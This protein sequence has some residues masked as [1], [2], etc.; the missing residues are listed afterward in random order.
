MLLRLSE[1]L[2]SLENFKIYNLYKDPKRV[3]LDNFVID[4]RKARK[5]SVFFALKGQRNDG[6]DFVKDVHSNG[7]EI[8]VVE[9]KLDNVGITQIV[10]NSSIKALGKIAKSVIEKVNPK[11]IGITG[12]NGK[13]TTKELMYHLLKPQIPIFR[14]PGNLNTEIGLPLSILNYYNREKI[15]VLE[16]GISKKGDME[17][18]IFL[19]KPDA[20]VFLNS[21]SAHIGNFENEFEIFEEKSKLMRSIKKGIAVLY[22][23]E[24]RF[25]KLSKELEKEVRSFFF[26]QKNGHVRL[27][28][29][30]YDS[31]NFKTFAN[32]RL[33]SENLS[34]ELNGIWNRGQLLDLCAAMCMVKG[35]G[36]DIVSST[37]NNFSPLE[38]RFSVRTINE[39]IVI[40]DTYNAS[41][42]SLK[43]ALN[44][45]K[46]I[47]ARRKI[48]VLGSI[49]EQGRKS[50]ETHKKLGEI[51]KS[52]DIDHV[53]VYSL[54]PDIEYSVDIMKDKVVMVSSELDEITNFLRTFLQPE[55]LIYFKASRGVEIEK[56]MEKI[57][58]VY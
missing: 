1:I 24:E 34:L 2:D 8:A 30:K 27:L 16:L 41:I 33:F 57:C 58:S 7:A 17:N 36:F 12:S 38:N 31:K 4:S 10:V 47:N 44:A 43:E 5:G 56:V 46:S 42:E 35:M 45:I 20:G 28:N 54:F 3:I 55:D 48:A 40:N 37:L 21:G 14:N 23:D 32:I 18:L 26:G 22:G 19:F 25:L 51:M 11:I 53:I 29:W 15:L 9:K 52:S 50:L 39:Y 49:L 6:H 13:T